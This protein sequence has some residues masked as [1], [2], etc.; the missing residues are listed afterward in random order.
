MMADSASLTWT[1]HLRTLFQIYAL[2]DPLT[3]LSTQP[4]SKEK[5]KVMCKTAVTRADYWTD[6]RPHPVVGGILTTLDVVRA[7]IHIKMLSGA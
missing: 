2:P 7:R 3:M 4:W 1:A 6:S 5:W